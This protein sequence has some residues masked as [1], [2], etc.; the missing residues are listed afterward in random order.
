L[1]DK[2]D[3]L[4]EKIKDGMLGQ[5]DRIKLIELYR[6]TYDLV[7]H[8]HGERLYKNIQNFLEIRA[9]EITS[10]IKKIDEKE[11]DLLSSFTT[12]WKKYSDFIKRASDILLYLDY[13]F[14]RERD[15]QTIS[16]TCI[17]SFYNQ[18]DR[19]D[20]F[21]EKLSDSIIENCFSTHKDEYVVKEAINAIEAIDK[22][23]K[24]QFY[25]KYFEPKFLERTR[26]NYN[27]ILGEMFSELNYSNFLIKIDQIKASSM[28]GKMFISDKTRNKVA[29]I[30]TEIS[31]NLCE[32][33]IADRKKGL[34]YFIEN[35]LIGEIKLFYKNCQS[36]KL[37][38]EKA[39]NV[40]REYFNSESGRIRLYGETIRKIDN[41]NDFESTKQYLGKIIRFQEKMDLVNK[42]SA[43]E[44]KFWFSYETEKDENFI[45]NFCRYYDHLI[46]N[47]LISTQSDLAKY[48]IPLMLMLIKD[49]NELEKE[50]NKN[51]RN[52]FYRNKSLNIEENKNCSKMEKLILKPINEMKLFLIE[53]GIRSNINDHIRNL[54]NYPVLSKSLNEKI[55]KNFGI[56]MSLFVVKNFN[57]KDLEDKYEN[58]ILPNELEN[59]FKEAQKFYKSREHRKAITFLPIKNNFEIADSQNFVLKC[60]LGQMLIMLLFN[61]YEQIDFETLLVKTGLTETEAINSIELINRKSGNLILIMSEN[62]KKWSELVDDKKRGIVVDRKKTLLRLNEKL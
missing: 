46:E 62:G 56:K 50:F 52:R 29:T 48:K 51:L 39:L 18:F 58:V 35:N 34:L 3:Q 6:H 21:I 23:N 26:T 45:L 20:N 10:K 47:R 17:K 36:S 44:K 19:I 9:K 54:K 16:E 28:K 14:C 25:E 5:I 7:H 38:F 11:N 60:D 53:N 13:R 41:E 12:I 30:I 33:I 2:A 61:E 24:K 57:W 40:N 55:Q 22:H 59:I 1:K 43:I 31:N 32:K 8:K 27:Q 49:K 42:N 37:V 15:E 4:I